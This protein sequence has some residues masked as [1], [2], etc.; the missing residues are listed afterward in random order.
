MYL[1]KCIQFGLIFLTFTSIIFCESYES[2]AVDKKLLTWATC[3][4]TS[5]IFTYYVFTGRK[6]NENIP[7]INLT[8]RATGGGVQNARLLI[9]READIG[10]TTTA[11][12]WDAIQGKGPF[13]GKPFQDFRLLY[14]SQTNPL[15]FVVSEKSGVKD[16]YGLEGKLYTPGILG[17]AAEISA[18]DIFRVLGVHP[19][20]RHMNYADAL[21]A[22]K[23]ETIVG[24]SKNGAPDSSILEI[25]SAMKIKILSISDS[26]MD[27]ILRNVA[28]VKK[29][30][31][32][33]GMYPGIGAFTT[34]ENEWS[35]YV[36]TD[37]PAEV[38]YKIVKTVWEKKGRD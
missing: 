13:Q 33:S 38:A 22:M 30:V 23:N 27:K 28:G 31:V 7:E 6:L 37:F 8:V 36:R 4:T 11:T 26:D 5:G 25:L 18:M 16:I 2:L 1:R 35:E 12:V 3:P 19:K 9:N 34:V 29:V 10:G 15:Q 24:F 14:V 32:P 21:E 17:S 20:I